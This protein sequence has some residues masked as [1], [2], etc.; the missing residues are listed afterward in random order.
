MNPILALDCEKCICCSHCIDT[1]PQQTI[2]IQD[3]C[4][5]RKYDLKSCFLLLS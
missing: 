1:C 2:T 5:D 4:F 3:E